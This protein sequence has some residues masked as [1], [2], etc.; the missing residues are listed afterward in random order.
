MEK[1]AEFSWEILEFYQYLSFGPTV[2][3]NEPGLAVGGEEDG[4]ASLC[5][6][7]PVNHTPGTG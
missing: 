7:S 4:G 1:I 5:R 2:Q 3:K 6:L